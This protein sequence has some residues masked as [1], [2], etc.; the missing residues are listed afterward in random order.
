ML[1]EDDGG[2]EKQKK[3]LPKC[4]TPTN[5]FYLGCIY[6]TSGATLT[7]IYIANNVVKVVPRST[8]KP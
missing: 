3:S 8:F 2:S 1:K 7:I 4:S 5:L 6:N